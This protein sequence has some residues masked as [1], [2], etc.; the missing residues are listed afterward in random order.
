MAIVNYEKLLPYV[1]PYVPECPE[2]VILSHIAEAAMRFCEQS[3]LWVFDVDSDT[4]VE[5]EDIYDIDVPTGAV[6]EDVLHLEV[7][8]RPIARVSD[9]GLP[10]NFSDRAR[11]PEYYAIYRDTQIRVYPKPDQAYAFRGKAVAKPTLD[12]SGIENFI[13]TTY[14]R[15][16]ANGAI[17]QLAAIPEK[18]WTNP[19]IS[20]VYGQQFNAAITAARVRDHRTVNQ[21]VRPRPFA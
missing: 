3:Y 17:S 4:F 5:G 8:G 15:A 21:R 20:Q 12:A 10:P 19:T 2:F 9:A 14:G 11:R 18:A 7:D 1:Q 6:L 16:I 13:Y